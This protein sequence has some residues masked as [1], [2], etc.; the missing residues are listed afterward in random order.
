MDIHCSWYYL[1]GNMQDTINSTFDIISIGISRFSECLGRNVGKHYIYIAVGERALVAPFLSRN[2]LFP[3][4]PYQSHATHSLKTRIQLF[5]FQ[6]RQVNPK[7]A[8]RPCIARHGTL[9][10]AETCLREPHTIRR[11]LTSAGPP[12]V[13]LSMLQVYTLKFNEPNCVVVPLRTNPHSLP[14]RTNTSLTL[15]TVGRG[16]LP[17]SSPP[18]EELGSESSIRSAPRRVSQSTMPWRHR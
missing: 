13:I 9:R 17:P 2:A 8:K 10:W 6:L 11:Q 4:E 3:T 14:F 7:H 18:W 12:R 16:V 1:C 5:T 15:T